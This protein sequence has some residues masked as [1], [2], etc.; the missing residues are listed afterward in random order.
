MKRFYFRH[1]EASDYQPVISVVNEWWEGRIMADMLPRLFFVHFRQTSFVVENDGDIIGFLIGFASQ[2]FADEAYI[3]FVGVHPDYRKN[4]L[5][6]ALYE[7]F[8]QAV[9]ELGRSRI[10]CVTSPLNKGSVAFHLRMGFSMEP[11]EKIVEG[12][13]VVTDYDGRGED[14]VVFSKLLGA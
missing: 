14:R 11:S 5:G 6:R 4:G 7:R 10:S 13:S 3:H 12:M 1:A 2:T 8:F 9:K